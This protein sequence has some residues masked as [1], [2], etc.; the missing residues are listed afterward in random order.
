MNL[1]KLHFSLYEKGKIHLS[2]HFLYRPKPQESQLHLPA[3]V[4]LTT[5]LSI[6]D[7]VWLFIGVFF[8]IVYIISAIVSI[9][10]GAQQAIA[11]KRI[12]TL[13]SSFSS[14]TNLSPT[15]RTTIPKPPT[16][17]TGKV[18]STS[19]PTPV[20]TARPIPII[21][22]PTSTPCPGVN[23]N[24]WGYNFISGNL[25]YNLPAGFCSYFACVANFNQP[26]HMHSGYVV[27]CNDGMYTQFGG[28]PGT[29]GHHG[30]VLRLLYAH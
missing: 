23:C 24:P 22:N 29:C 5:R 2:K 18:P 13:A 11:A 4:N 1:Q 16:V 26:H 14:S 21:F 12:S 27:E 8:G 3:V 30:G 9:Q 25:I 15:L 17:S 20:P 19:A 6:R 10:V 7:K 28:S